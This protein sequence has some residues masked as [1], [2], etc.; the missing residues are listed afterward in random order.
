MRVFQ[1]TEEHIRGT[2]DKSD[3]GKWAYL[4]QGC[5]MFFDSKK[6]AIA[7]YREVFGSK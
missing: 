1:I 3:I 2:L 4:V 5:W 7:S 6:E